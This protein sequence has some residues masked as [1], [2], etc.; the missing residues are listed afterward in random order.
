MNSLYQKDGKK[1]RWMRSRDVHMEI[2]MIVEVGVW[3]RITQGQ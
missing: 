2:K 1:K 3:I